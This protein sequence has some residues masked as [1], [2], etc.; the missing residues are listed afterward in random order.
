MQ[1]LEKKV[2]CPLC[3][4]RNKVDAPRCTICTRPLANDPLPSQALYQE[5]LWSSTIATSRGNTGTG[6]SPWFVV[7]VLVVALALLNYFVVGLGPSWA[8]EPKAPERG[9][10]WKEYR[11]DPAYRADLPGT[12]LVLPVDVAGTRLTAAAVWVDSNWNVARDGTTQSV[13]A[14]DAGLRTAHGL[15]VTASGPAPSDTANAVG[16]M[17]AALAPGVALEEGGVT[18]DGTTGRF[19]LRTKFAGWPLP[20]DEGVV[21][22]TVRVDGGT[23]FVAAS[24]VRGGDDPA[25][26]ERLVEQFVPAGT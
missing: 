1:M 11:G 16:A 2:K 6:V 10:T 8:H 9:F 26:A 15:I 18:A 7:G 17:V 22:A 23:V 12:P 21:R 4:A 24:F 5:A 3:G 20:A 25:L 13:A 19:L 14:L